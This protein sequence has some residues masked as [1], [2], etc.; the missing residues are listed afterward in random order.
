MRRTHAMMPLTAQE[1]GV[2]RLLLD[3]RFSF[4]PHHVFDLGRIGRL[5]IDFLVFFGSGVVLECTSCG[6]KRGRAL[7]EVR[8][9]AAYM[10]YRFGLLRSV[11][12]NL[13]CGAF[14]EAPLEDSDRLRIE[15]AKILRNANFAAHSSEEL[16]RLLPKVH[17]C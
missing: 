4:E 2:R 15:L 11:F 3:R 5:S 7:A 12:P 9:R 14:I 1:E 6:S 16:E 13:T 17:G 8:R 10:D